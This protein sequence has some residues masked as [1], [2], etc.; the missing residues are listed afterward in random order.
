M[1][2]QKGKVQILWFK[3][4]HMMAC[5]AIINLR[6]VLLQPKPLETILQMCLH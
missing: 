6:S 3:E 1:Q 4:K 2:I 5:K